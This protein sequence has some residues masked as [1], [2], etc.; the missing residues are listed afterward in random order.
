[1]DTPPARS[2]Q[3]PGRLGSGVT[4]RQVADAAGVSR[5]T[6]ARTLGNYGTVDPALQAKVL[7][8]AQRLGYRRNALARSVSSGRSN[9]IGVVI[10]DIED[11]HFARTVRGISDVAGRRGFD[12]ILANTDEKI[13]AE[14]AA[15]KVFLDKRVDGFIVSPASG[16]AAT[17]LDEILQMPRPLVLV[18]RCLPGLDCDWVGAD[19][20]ASTYAVIERLVAAGHRRI[21]LVAAT[22][23]PVADIERG[24]SQP[25]S[26]IARRIQALRDAAGALGVEY[27]LHTGA[28]SR[29][30]TRQVVRAAI[31]LP[32]PP[33][34]LLAS[35]S[36]VALT[37]F[38]VLRERRLSVPRRISL[39]SLD[40]AQWMTVSSP[41]ISA[42]Q[43]PSHAMGVRA[44]EVLLARLSGDGPAERTHTLPNLVIDRESVGPV[45][46]RALAPS[47]RKG[48]R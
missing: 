45:P 48:V 10:S 11:P 42:V 34:A 36:E 22:S 25:I 2:P 14:R 15:V 8:A 20:Y 30:R 19:D 23:H 13:D 35:Y 37:A 18:D 24:T 4:L 7:D 6:A 28:M 32:D 46:L 41:A 3:Q 1:M 43:R 40:D 16:M 27:R 33:T 47:V 31:D 44:T 17:H 9:T 12:V 21:D 39:V 5:S 38:Q 29:D 26:P